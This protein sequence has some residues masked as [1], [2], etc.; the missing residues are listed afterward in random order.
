MGPIAWSPPAPLLTSLCVVSLLASP[1]AADFPASVRD[2]TPNQLLVLMKRAPAED[3]IITDVRAS[4]S[5]GSILYSASFEKNDDG[6]AWMF[7]L[8]VDRK[9]FARAQKDYEREGYQTSLLRSVTA[10]G[11]RY[12]TAIWTREKEK[13][14][15][16][17]LPSGPI[18]SS[19]ASHDGTLPLDEMVTAFL[20]E[21]NVA[22]ATVAVAKHGKLLYSR[23][24]GYADV[25]VLQK[26]QPDATMRI[27]SVSKPITGVAIMMLID[28]GK[29][30]LDTTVMPVLRNAGF[31]KPTGDERWDEITV[32]HLLNHAGGWDRGVSEDPMFQVIEASRALKLKKPARQSDIIRWKLGHPLDFDP[33]QKYVYSNFGYCI[34]GRII[35]A[36]SGQRYEEWV[37]ENILKPR[38]MVDTRLGKTPI[39]DRGESEVRYHMQKLTKHTSYWDSVRNGVKATPLVEAPYGRWSV[40]VMDAHGGWVSSAPDLLRFIG[41]LDDWDRPLMSEASIQQMLARP[42]L[43]D[44]GSEASYWY[45]GGWSVRSAGRG[46]KILDRRN[47]WHNGAL[48]GTSTLV[49][50]RWDGYSWAVLFNTDKSVSGERLS[51]LID[52]KMHRAVDRVSDWR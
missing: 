1:V 4:T 24:F 46:G 5:G 2:Q 9:R 10:G 3:M 19:G 21:H 35:A 51:G 50:R 15:A 33:G 36:V 48:S 45:G 18:P 7:L 42:Q 52:S 27:A 29:L 23:G 39:A 47:I 34:L 11:K 8:H 20:E 16:L 30:T 41:G 14:Q 13:P 40:E 26:M 22:G 17:V 32:R 37:T 25:T 12:Y 6:V 38:G 43:K 31:P 49:V 44:T 28:Q